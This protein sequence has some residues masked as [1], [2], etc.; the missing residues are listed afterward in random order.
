MGFKKINATH[1]ANKD[2]SLNI[3][4]FDTSSRI[5]PVIF[6][7]KALFQSSWGEISINLAGNAD[8]K[9]SDVGCGVVA[10]GVPTTG[11][12]KVLATAT[13]SVGVPRMSSARGGRLVK[14]RNATLKGTKVRYLAE[15][16]SF[17]LTEN[18]K[19]EL[20]FISVVGRP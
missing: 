1:Y 12:D 5:E 10:Y 8:L 15:A 14:G 7:A 3:V 9:M 19:T 16:L 20:A 2:T 11:L 6:N 17:K 4:I 13:Q 18:G